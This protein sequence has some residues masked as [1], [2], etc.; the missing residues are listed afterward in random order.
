MVLK[1]SENNS[2][3]KIAS[4]LLNN[5]IAI[6]PCDTIY[7][8]VSLTGESEERIRD[9]KGRDGDKPFIRLIGSG[10][11]LP[12]FTDAVI[13]QEVLD[14]WPCPLTLIVPSKNG[15]TVALRVPEDPYLLDLLKIIRQPV[16]S[17]SVNFSGKPALN[18][19]G[20][21]KESFETM[22]DLIV[23]GGDLC[24]D[25]APSTILDVTVKPYRILRY[26]KCRLDE[27]ILR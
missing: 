18:R 1:K 6:M 10:E 27:N 3:L 14:L 13:K 15:D 12:L 16:V 5:G 2:V 24:D 4:V 8:I 21:I 26:G 7:G 25:A 20:E 11:D 22:V 19:I 9:I 17:T 23:D